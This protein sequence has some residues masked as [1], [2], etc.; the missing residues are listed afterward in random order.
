MRPFHHAKWIFAN[1]NV[2]DDL[3]TDYRQCFSYKGGEVTLIL[4][5]DSDYTLYIN[6][7]YV[8]SNQYGDFE[9]YKICDEIDLTP[10]LTLGEN[11]LELT[12][13]YCGTN[14]QRYRRGT[15]GVIFEGFCEGS[16]LFSSGTHTLSRKNPAYTSGRCQLITPQL[17][18]TFH[19]DA[20]KETEDGFSPSLEIEK[21]T[22]F[23][24]RPIQKLRICQPRPVLEQKKIAPL[25]YLIDFGVEVVGLATLRFT[26][27]CVQT[28][29]V[30][31]GE[32]LSDGRVRR[33]IHNRDFSFTYRAKA[34][35]NDFTNY[36]LRLG[37]RYLEVTVEED[38]DIFYI[39]LL[40][41]VYVA[42]TR[43]DICVEEGLP[44]DIYS[45][46]V[47]T[48]HLCMMEHYVDTPWREQCLYAFDSRNQMLAGYRV[49]KNKNYLYARSNLVLLSEDRREDGLLSI[50]APSGVSLAIPS[51]SI[52]YIIAM[53]EYTK[54]T[55]DISLAREYLF[56]IEEILHAFLKR[57]N[58]NGLILTF[59]DKDKWNFYDWSPYLSGEL[60]EESEEVADLILN[61]LVLMGLDAYEKMCALTDRSP[62]FVGESEALRLAIREHFLTED[63]AF[64]HMEGKRILTS[65]GNALAILTGTVQGDE[66]RA[67]ADRLANGEF[68]PAS[69][70]MKIWVYDALLLVDEERYREMI[71]GDIEERYDLMIDTGTVWETEEGDDAFD[72]AGSLCHGWSAVPVYIY[73]R[74]GIAYYETAEPQNTEI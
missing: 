43:D 55:G 31:Y 28:V 59:S 16:S 45:I 1:T 3:Y 26:S 65:L 74:L 24:P 71:L 41:Q 9:H 37:C 52:Y 53:Y 42:A 56:K 14:L 2:C 19:Y 33:K 34:G 60:Y 6:G 15:A 29:T 69:L 39:G 10:Y 63:G 46:S 48:L 23:F 64:T 35:K 11:T 8:A 49:F 36:M 38:I 58:E 18:Y 68:T 50:C 57:R 30:A 73:H 7:T 22:T 72:G 61:T 62:A 40:P 25:T 17:G 51:F 27:P 21:K 20:T 5:A 66:A 47:R 70:S 13:Y 54:E 4:S 44:Y 12:V 32:S 67:L